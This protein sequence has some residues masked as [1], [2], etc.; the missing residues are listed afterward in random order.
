MDLGLSGRT[1]LVTGAG[2]G[3]GLTSAKAL[4]AEGCFVILVDREPS[5]IN[6]MAEESP[7]QYAAIV[8][9]LSTRTGPVTASERALALRGNVSILVMCAG[10]YEKHS[11]EDTSLEEWE[12]VQD[13]N[14][15]SNFLMAKHLVPVM[16]RAGWGR[17]IT[18][19]SVSVVTGGIAAGPA[20]V[21][22]KAGVM[23]LTRS[24]AASAGRNGVTVNTI[25]PGFIDTPMTAG[26]PQDRTD[27]V[28]ARTS[29]KRTG[30]PEDI[31]G[32]V[33]CVASEAFGYVTGQ[34]IDVNGGY[35]FSG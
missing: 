30:V 5:V 32:V 6:A 10:V 15:R 22:S 29:L 2:S 9:D 18:V 16:E 13:I 4:A 25:R 1:A 35:H 34:T 21:T 23:G 28:V 31:S 11:W 14:V 3:M 33:T 17:V 19:T 7:E 20:Y 26:R 27:T 12:R 8:E 24:L